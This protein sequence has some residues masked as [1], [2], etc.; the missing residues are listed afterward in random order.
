V[1]AISPLG[2]LFSSLCILDFFVAKNEF[3]IRASKICEMAGGDL[4]N[5]ESAKDSHDSIDC[6]DFSFQL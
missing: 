6:K 1:K 3:L 4:S 5:Q 2:F